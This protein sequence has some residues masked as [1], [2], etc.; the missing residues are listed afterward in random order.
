[1]K[2]RVIMA[3]ALV[4]CFGASSAFAEQGSGNE[5]CQGV[6]TVQVSP[7]WFPDGRQITTEFQ[8]AGIIFQAQDPAQDDIISGGEFTNPSRINFG[9]PV[10]ALVCEVTITIDDRNSNPQTYVLTAYDASGRR[11]NQA[12][13]ADGGFASLPLILTVK[14][15][16]NHAN[17]AYVILTEQPAGARVLQRVTYKK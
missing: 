15:E 16:S 8:S 4:T 13:Q 2:E 10:N 6:V 12:R 9:A 3:A 11:V 1:M 14:A 7:T 5:P 17:I